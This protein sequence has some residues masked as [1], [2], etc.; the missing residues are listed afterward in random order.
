MIVEP[1]ASKD[2]PP[3]PLPVAAIVSLTAV[4]APQAVPVGPAAPAVRQVRVVPPARVG[5][6]V[7]AVLPVR[8]V[9]AVALAAPGVRP[10]AAPDGHPDQPAGRRSWPAA[11]A[12]R[13]V[14][15]RVPRQVTTRDRRW[16]VRVPQGTDS[17]GSRRCSPR[18]AS[19]AA[20][21]AR[22]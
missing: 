16:P 12:A 3:C 9:Q 7:R 20:G 8:A 21:R 5:P 2:T 19:A 6:G 10:E 17:N 14:P 13:A 11:P 22:N 15:H 1:H 4:I 18:P